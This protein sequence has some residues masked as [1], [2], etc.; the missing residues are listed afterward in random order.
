[1]LNQ[2]QQA[3]VTK[4]LTRACGGLEEASR[5]CLAAGRPYSVAQLS[6][7]QTV[8]SGCSMP[9]DV[10]AILEDYCGESVVGQALLDARPTVAEIGNLMS[11]AAETTEAAAGFQAKVRRAVA[12]GVVSAA[13]QADLEAEADALFEQARQSREAIQRLRVHA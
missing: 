2:R 6:R 7:C 13:E 10:I 4:R 11:E 1:M 8:G 9:L 12:D 3:S 5:A